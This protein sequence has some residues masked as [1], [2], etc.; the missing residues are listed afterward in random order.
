VT[1]LRRAVPAILA[2]MAA[3]PARAE[4]PRFGSFQLQTSSYRPNIDAEFKGKLGCQ[5]GTADCTPFQDIFGTGRSWVFEFQLAKSLYVG[6]PGTVDLGLGAGYF[7]RTGKGLIQGTLTPSGDD[8][9][10][11]IIPLSLSLTWRFDAFADTFPLVPYARASLL[12]YQWW[13]TSGSGST[14]SVAG[15]GSGSGAT[16]G[17]GVAGGVAFLLDFIDPQLAREMDRD[18]GVN[19]TYLFMEAAR[20][21][22][23]GFGS[24]KSW[25]LSND[26]GLTWSGGILFVF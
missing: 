20:N 22:V 3:L 16:N 23:D 5:G 4:S 25:I 15:V 11:R 7:S 9:T 6:R 24:K 26:K 14:A 2:L 10:L 18:V 8:T 17:Y 12:R 19:H 1:G 21:T 13:V